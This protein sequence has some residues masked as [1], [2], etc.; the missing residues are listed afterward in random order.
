MSEAIAR[1]FSLQAQRHLREDFMPKIRRCLDELSP[2]QV[3]WRPNPHSNSVGNL[4]LH[5]QGNVRQWILAGLGG[6][7]D[8][9]HR[10]GE[11]S[12][13]DPIAAARLFNQLEETLRESFAVID[14]LDVAQL[15]RKRRIQAYEVDGLQAVFHVIEHFSY[16]TG[17]I[18]YITKFLLDKDLAFY[19]S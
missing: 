16:H 11:F 19:D 9:R 5:L 12:S 17:Q 3:W 14:G 13:R 1:S 4:L 2:E 6:R 15:L 10:D 7:P 8:N 18:V